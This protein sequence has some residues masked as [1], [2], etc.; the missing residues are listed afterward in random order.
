MWQ[1]F[2]EHARRTVFYAQEEAGRLGEN[3]VSTEHL[4]LGLLRENDCVAV[5]VLDRM[6]IGL[7]RL[8]SA[9]ERQVLRGDGRLGQD[10]QLT[11]RS[12]KIIDYAYDEARR[13][14]NKYIGTEHILLGLIREEGGMAG[15]VL[16]TL[17]VSLECARAEIVNLQNTDPE[18][19]TELKG[20]TDSTTPSDKVRTNV[21]ALRFGDIGSFAGPENRTVVEIAADP[22][23]FQELADVFLAHDGY[24]YQELLDLGR[25]FVA[26][27]GERVKNLVPPRDPNT[28]FLPQ[29]CLFIRILEG[30]HEGRKG[31]I[32]A[33]SFTLIGPDET[34]F[35]PE[36]SSLPSDFDEG[37]F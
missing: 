15:R 33:D 6:G 36:A 35:P 10:M 11:P 9:I 34:P 8:R 13:L 22:L 2:T 1:R 16:S 32:S 19:L 18:V 12:K 24:G 4:L 25:V 5:R 23:A 17:G 37:V 30:V 27:V 31:W 26:I 20:Q 7:N 14:N 28:A 29:R 3:Y 21:G